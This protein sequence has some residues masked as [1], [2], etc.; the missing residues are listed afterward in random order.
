MVN[1]A[2]YIPE[3]LWEYGQ[4]CGMYCYTHVLTLSPPILTQHFTVSIYEM[5]QVLQ[6][7][8]H[9]TVDM[10]QVQS[11]SRI[12]SRMGL[13]VLSLQKSVAITEHNVTVNSEVSIGTTEYLTV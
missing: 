6:R 1:S 5:T 2:H 8:L 7:T 13:N 4:Y 10:Y 9:R 3:L 12:T 11:H